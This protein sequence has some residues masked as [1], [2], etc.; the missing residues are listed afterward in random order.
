M[1]QLRLQWIAAAMVILACSALPAMALPNA[2]FQIGA[3][4]VHLIDESMWT[5]DGVNG[6]W[7]MEFSYSGEGAAVNGT[8]VAKIDPYIS[9]TFAAVN[10]LN[11]DLD[12]HYGIASPIAPPIDQP[13]V[14]YHS[15][16]GSWTD[17]QRNGVHITPIQPDV[18]GDGTVEMAVANANGVNLGV[19]TGHGFHLNA[20][21][22]GANS[23]LFGGDDAGPQPGPLG[24]WNSLGLDL[25][26]RLSGR[27]LAT[28]N[29][30][31]DIQPVPEPG[32]ILLL[33]MGL[34]GLGLWK[35]RRRG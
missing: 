33:G 12:F 4:P 16:S 30:Y 28:V 21:Y 1:K 25:G 13:T 6:I 7:S 35:V 32:A 20:P 24:T 27:D 29:G 10:L 11:A 23:G 8:A 5:W 9:Y 26:F 2:W 15:F 34:F 17:V 31:V 18:D 3:G 14:V 19:D 22:P